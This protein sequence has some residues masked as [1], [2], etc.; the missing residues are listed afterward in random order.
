MQSGDVLVVTQQR[1]KLS[2]NM[3]WEKVKNNWYYVTD[4]TD[5]VRA[6][7]SEVANGLFS[8]NLKTFI[9]LEGAKKA[10]EQENNILEKINDGTSKRLFDSE[11]TI[12]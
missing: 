10:A 2:S 1:R 7:V 6:T 12:N 9:S 3:R 5:Q 4:D 11:S 8:Y